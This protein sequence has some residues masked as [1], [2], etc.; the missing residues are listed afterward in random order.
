VAT[1]DTSVEEL[2]R[3]IAAPYPT[4]T[5]DGDRCMRRWRTDRSPS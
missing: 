5:S 3:F 1:A 2:E 4:A